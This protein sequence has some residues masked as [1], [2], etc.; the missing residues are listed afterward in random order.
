MQMIWPD[1][2]EN[3]FLPLLDRAG[4]ARELSRPGLGRNLAVVVVGHLYTP[5]QE[6]QM[7]H[8]WTALLTGPGFQRLIFL[9][10]GSNSNIDG[11]IIVRESAI[12]QANDERRKVVATFA[13]L[14]AATRADVANSSGHSIR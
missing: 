11:L 8:D 14:P 1:T 2:R 6:A 9:R 7:F 10:A 13:A 5:D 4:V 3:G 12:A